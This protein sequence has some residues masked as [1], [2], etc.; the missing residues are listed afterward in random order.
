MACLRDDRGRNLSERLLYAS[1]RHRAQG[2]CFALPLRRIA[3]THRGAAS[4]AVRHLAGGGA[5]R[6]PAPVPVA[7]A[8]G[9]PVTAEASGHAESSACRTPGEAALR[10]IELYRQKIDAE[11]EAMLQDIAARSS[12]DAQRSARRARSAVDRPPPPP[13]PPE[14]RPRTFSFGDL[15]GDS[16]DHPGTAVVKAPTAYAVSRSSGETV[17]RHVAL[18]LARRPP[19]ELARPPAATTGSVPPAPAPRPGTIELATARRRASRLE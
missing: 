16:E 18:D 17:E 5:A 1:G 9:H 14:Q 12:S 8:H 15:C 13:P 10:E 7:V 4:F 3:A 2:A 6:F 11:Y 19:S